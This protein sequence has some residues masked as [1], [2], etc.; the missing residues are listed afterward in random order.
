[1]ICSSTELRAVSDWVLIDLELSHTSFNQSVTLQGSLQSYVASSKFLRLNIRSIL[2]QRRIEC[3]NIDRHI[4]S[5]RI[6]FYH[7][8][9]VV[10]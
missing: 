3:V 1:M 6:D 2:S 7:T 4:C 10:C 9:L 8:E 5:L